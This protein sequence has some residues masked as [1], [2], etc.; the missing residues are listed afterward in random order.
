[1][2]ISLP[3]FKNKKEI[4]LFLLLV[5]GI[6]FINLYFEYKDYKS[7]ISK[8]VYETDVYVLNQYKKKK[9]NRDYFVL[10][11]KAKE[12]FVFYTTSYEDLKDLKDR[13]L[14]VKIFTKNISFFDFLKGFY[15]AV[16]DMRLYPKEKSLKTI[17]KDF[18]SSSH[19]DKDLKELFNALFL[20]SL[21]SNDLREKIQFLG[22]SHLIAISGF[23]LGVLFFILYFVLK[24]P[25]KFFQTKFFPYRNE[26][27]DL[28]IFIIFIL[29]LYLKMINFAPSLLRAFVMLSFGFFLYVRAIEILSFETLLYSVLIILSLFPKLI[30]SIGFWFSVAGVFYIYLFLKYFKHLKKW[31]IFVLLNFWVFF[32]MMP[33]VHFFFP[34]FSFVQFLSPIIS[35][36]FVIFYPL[37]IFL[38]LILKGDLLDSHLKALLSLKGEVFYWKSSFS[39][40]IFYIL[41]SFFSVFNKIIF[42][43]LILLLAIFLIENIAQFQSV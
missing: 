23:H 13:K 34:T 33:I 12:G 43:I 38:H 2:Q 9:K 3:L 40:L 15:A 35:M 20:A 22:I 19:N 18:I 30:F 31:Q 37:E 11:L 42:Y 25:Y 36:L 7:F 29:F 32:A 27:L 41:L 6:F 10:K 26:T 14:R 28:T 17:L 5:F 1:M 4:F 8:R 39:F 24:Y 16:F 21:I